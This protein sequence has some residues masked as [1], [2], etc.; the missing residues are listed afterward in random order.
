MRP[1]VCDA[2]GLAYDC[3]HMSQPAENAMEFDPVV[4]PE[5]LR[6]KSASAIVAAGEFLFRRGDVPRHL[7][8]VQTGEVRLV[9]Y[10]RRGTCA[11]LQ[12]VRRGFLAEGSMAS[13]AYHCDAEVGAES[14]IAAVPLAAVWAALDADGQFRR[15]WFGYLAREVRRLRMQCERLA[16]PTAEERL[17]H[18]I[19]TE[20]Q[21]GMVTLPATAKA[22][23][24]ELGLSHEALY[25]TIGRMK[26]EGRLVVEGA[27]LALSA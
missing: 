2:G 10:S 26:R 20:G 8:Y 18:F 7:Y 9:R 3:G 23:A 13:P 1:I 5:S 16:L 27:Q 15:A 24:Q 6:S 17:V 12:T 21:E 14:R 4:F 22:L 11:V 19:E 25:R